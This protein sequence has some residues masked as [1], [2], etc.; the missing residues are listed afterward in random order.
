MYQIWGAF[1][2]DSIFSTNLILISNCYISN[3]KFLNL[4][5]KQKFIAKLN[6]QDFNIF[7]EL[8]LIF[9]FIFNY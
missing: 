4:K 5:I 1:R 2:L 3:F 9:F 8:K 7:D 6:N